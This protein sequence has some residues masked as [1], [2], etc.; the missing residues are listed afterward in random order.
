MSNP[1]F[2]VNTREVAEA[3]S[4]Y[5]S[6]SSIQRID[7]EIIVPLKF[8]GPLKLSEIPKKD[9]LKIIDNFTLNGRPSNFNYIVEGDKIYYS[10]KGLT[11]NWVDIS[12][13]A[14]AR[15]NLFEFLKNNYDFRGYNSGER[16]L[17]ESIVN[18]TFDYDVHHTNIVHQQV[19]RS[20]YAEKF[21]EF[22][23][24]AA[25]TQ[26]PVVETPT[27][28]PKNGKSNFV[29]TPYVYSNETL[30]EMT[31]M[32]PS[33]VG[34]RFNPLYGW[35]SLSR[36]QDVIYE[37]Q[38]Q[39][40]EN[41]PE[42]VSANSGS[43]STKGVPESDV[44]QNVT[45][46]TFD[47]NSV[48]GP[49]RILYPHVYNPPAG[50]PI[51]QSIK[52]GF[53]DLYNAVDRKWHEYGGNP[54]AIYG[55]I[56]NGLSRQYAKWNDEP[57]TVPS[58]EGQTIVASGEYGII[59]GSYV[60]DTIPTNYGRRYII[61]ESL[62]VN[63]FTYAHRNR[64]QYTPIVSEGAPITA[65]TPFKPFGKH[66]K[67]YSTYIGVGSDGQFKVGDI[68][69]FG[70]GDYL[71]GTYSN[72]VYDF[73]KDANGN[74]KWQ[75]DDKH[76]N[77]RHNV[78]IVRVEHN[79]KII[80]SAP[81][82]VL[83][84]KNDKKGTTYGNVTGGRVLVQVGNELRLLSGSVANIDAEFTAMKERQG[85]D[86]GIFYTLDNGSYNRALRTYD[87]RFTRGD[88]EEYD[89]QN[90]GNSGNFLYIT[91]RTP[92][93]FEQDTVWTPNIR[94]EKD[95]SYQKGHPLQNSVEGVV[96]HHTTFNQSDNLAEVTR[97]FLNPK[98]EASA[99]VVIAGDGTRRI[100]AN[101]E[102]VAFHAGASKFGDRLNVN[103]F[104]LGIK[105]QGNTLNTPLTEAQIDSAV[106]YL[107]PL[108]RKYNIP[109][110]NLVTHEMVRYAYNQYAIANNMSTAPNKP[111]ITYAEFAKIIE[112][113]VDKIY[114]KK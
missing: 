25:K 35:Y 15:K 94:T 4:K 59:P 5:L 51:A 17:Y 33:I 39:D 11:D 29:F 101:P 105:F 90:Y 23:K 37:N 82:N 45:S 70:E 8:N 84:S 47:P 98:S 28:S 103:D 61:P 114:Y 40:S 69:I 58:F 76:Q 57:E 81:V 91:G 92:D 38:P 107:I 113:L 3:A 18:G 97:H 73:V 36:Q 49:S 55:T 21:N 41:V 68:S 66:D 77:Y 95:E 30:D 99:H 78:P 31:S 110:E 80:E 46:W 7:D 67:G 16:E 85:V 9:R 32:V 34:E 111:D 106:E 72:K 102:D 65:F 109:L 74:Y 89:Q 108:I 6:A 13:N 20:M 75:S 96:F 100:F 24:T 48:Y 87:G 53:E 44:T 10:R 54:R 26:D 22:G 14:T 86:Y 71:T 2:N 50:W 93:M 104:M 56:K 79:G 43:S 27:A 64:G 52:Q 12:D 112:K 62:D 60:G 83:A 19:F 88:L 63:E 1:K 42:S